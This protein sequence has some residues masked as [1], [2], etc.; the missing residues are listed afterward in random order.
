MTALL[1]EHRGQ[2]ARLR[3]TPPT[4]G[5]PPDRRLQ[6]PADRG[7]EYTQLDALRKRLVRRFSVKP[8]MA[9]EASRVR[10]PRRA[11]ETRA[12]A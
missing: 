8:L 9:S 5:V 10:V 1:S 7:A 4:F 11:E 3:A 2:A 12:C 6:A